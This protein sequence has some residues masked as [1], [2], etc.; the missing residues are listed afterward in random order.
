MATGLTRQYYTRGG[1]G[2]FIY[3]PDIAVWIQTEENGLIDLSSKIVDFDLSRQVNN[4][5]VFTCTF[6]N[7][8]ALY[9][10]RIRRMDKIVVFLKRIS[11][12]QVFSGYIVE[13]PWQT[14]VP[15]NATLRAECT[16][17]RLQHSYFDLQ[18]QESNELFPFFNVET[19]WTSSDGGAAATIVRLLTNVALW[20]PS[21]IHI[22]KIPIKWIQRAL[23][24][25]SNLKETY[26]NGFNSDDYQTILDAFSNLI[27]ANGW[28]GYFQDS[29]QWWRNN[30]KTVP[31]VA[32]AGIGSYSDAQWKDKVGR[33][34]YT[35][36]NGTTLNYTTGTT[37]SGTSGG[38]TV[39]AYTP[40]RE[41]TN[42][43]TT[44]TS[45]TTA[46]TVPLTGGFIHEDFPNLLFNLKVKG[47]I[48]KQ[49]TASSLGDILYL[50]MDAADSL[51]LLLEQF[52]KETG[53]TP[54]I[55]YGYLP[56]DDMVTRHNK[57]EK[58][59]SS[60][61]NDSEFGWGI[62][63]KVK[64]RGNLSTWLPKN[65]YKFG[66]YRSNEIDNIDVYVFRGAPKYWDS[67]GRPVED[68]ASFDLI[69]TF[70]FQNLSKTS[71]A[72]NTF[73]SSVFSFMFYYPGLD[74]A[75][76]S[77][78]GD[79]AWIN[80]TPVIEILK[81][82]APSSQRDFMSA[83][84]GDFVAFFP[85]RLGQYSNFPT[86]RVRDIEVVDFKSMIS[87]DSLTTHYIS[88]G[89]FPFPGGGEGHNNVTDTFFSGGM[90]T[91]QQGEVIKFLLGITDNT[92]AA[93]LGS[94][95]IQ[96]FGIR[97]KTEQ[98]YYIRNRGYNFAVALHRFQEFWANQWRFMVDFTYLPEIYPGMRIELVD[99]EPNPIAIYVE[100]VE[101]SGNR[102]SGFKTT[103]VASTPTVFQ[104]GKWT[105]LSFELAGDLLP[106][107]EYTKNELLVAN[108][109]AAMFDAGITSLT[110][111]PYQPPYGWK[112]VP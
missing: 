90:L 100:S 67:T 72:N 86:L 44:S 35:I 51:A 14:V 18:S 1:Q 5:S 62:A 89:D 16:L 15:G 38:Y 83:P 13:A 3:A 97:P 34:N 52:N 110:G 108:Q 107:D 56:F 87:D 43:T 76:E 78:T 79:R 104:D 25:A 42:T 58:I 41:T 23:V 102:T 99:R 33:V 10:R 61:I 68:K 101:H 39:G 20:D 75:S 17:K 63:I 11:W 49:N 8:F 105:M 19:D 57:G 45:N 22:Q 37:S 111:I 98:N 7:K 94:K 6:D 32:G 46:T 54:D 112:P 59:F 28:K 29:D 81:Q 53:K 40:D 103:V 95:I 48:Q 64:S 82:I 80:D 21:Q 36:E 31:G 91:L 84:N 96:K 65:G 93:D 85:D 66:W 4:V 12:L 27:D 69:G 92:E 47:F 71:G 73:D 9:D 109:K 2:T 77:L 30:G 60:P 74:F 50:R 55:V 70:A 88:W 106:R 26:N 24:L